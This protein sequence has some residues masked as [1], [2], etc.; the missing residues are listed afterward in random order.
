MSSLY[1]AL[2]QLTTL[3]R[4]LGGA[5][6]RSFVLQFSIKGKGAG[7]WAGPSRNELMADIPTK[8]IIDPLVTISGR[9]ER[10]CSLRGG[11]VAGPESRNGVDPRKKRLT[12]RRTPIND[13]HPEKA[14]PSLSLG[15][16]S[17]HPHPHMLFITLI[18]E[19]LSRK[20]V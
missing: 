14:S 12:P 4:R 15:L 13:R 2:Y 8:L 18:Q 16:T 3:T 19:Q 20:A 17:L 10:N 7:Q 1:Q 11:T 9:N 6:K 5:W